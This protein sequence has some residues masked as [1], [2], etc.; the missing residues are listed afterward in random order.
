MP[1]IR[2]VD[3]RDWKPWAYI[4][5]QGVPVWTV[6]PQMNERVVIPA[7]AIILQAMMRRPR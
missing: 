2:P 6:T 3:R 4:N 7:R 5:D 1:S